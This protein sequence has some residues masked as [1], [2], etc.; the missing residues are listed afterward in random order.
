[1]ISRRGFLRRSVEWCG[2]DGC[3][4]SRFAPARRR[5]AP[6]RLRRRWGIGE[7]KPTGPLDEAYWWK[8]RS[9]FNILDGMTFMNNG[10]EGPVPRVVI[11]ANERVVPR[12]RREPV[13]QL[14]PR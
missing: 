11:E 2:G 13:Q 12:D 10:T 1:M 4:T 9:Q 5:R 8:V 3:G 6:G 7:L 14:S